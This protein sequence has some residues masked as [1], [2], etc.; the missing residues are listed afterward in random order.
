MGAGPMRPAARQHDVARRQIAVGH[1]AP[2]RGA[3]RVGDLRADLEDVADRDR[4]A[5]D[6]RGQ[7]LALE[8]LHDQEVERDARAAL[9][10]LRRPAPRRA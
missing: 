6:P 10:A 3:E 1:S 4:T 7:R 2:V 9:A 5:R 8:V